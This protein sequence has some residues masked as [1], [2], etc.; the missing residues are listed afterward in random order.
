MPTTFDRDTASEPLGD[1]RHRVRFDPAW[2][3][4]RGPNGGYVAA[5]LV[6]AIRAEVPDATRALRS[7]TIHY[8]AV[9][10]EDEATV[11]VRVEREGRGMTTVSARCEQGGRTVALAL[12]AL[13]GPYPG[14]VEYADAVMPDAPAPEAIAPTATPNGFE[15]PAFSHRFDLRPALGALPLAGAEQALTGGWIRLSEE[16]PLDEALVVA[17]TDAWWP[18]PFGVAPRLL[19][20]PTIDLTVHLRA[21]LPRPFDDVLLEARSDTAREGYFEEDVRLFA[22]D[23]TLLAHARQLALAL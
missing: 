4:V 14:D 13:G 9:P 1:G 6:R 12:A 10:A 16:R 2:R 21:P 7:I 11:T 22:R 17:M 18:A 23:G 3:V 5:V 19:V 8:L 20:A 15:R